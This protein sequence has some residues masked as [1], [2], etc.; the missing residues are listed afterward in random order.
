MKYHP[1]VGIWVKAR[2]KHI[3]TFIENWEKFNLIQAFCVYEVP[4][5]LPYGGLVFLHAISVNKLL[6]VARYAGYDD[7]KGWYEHTLTEDS[8]WSGECE[9]I[10]N[11]FGPDRLHTHDE[12]DF[13]HFWTEQMGVRGLFFMKDIR[14]VADVISWSDSMKV[15]QV[16]RPLGFSYKYLTIAQAREFLRLCSMNLQIE[17]KGIGSPKVTMKS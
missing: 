12:S 7:V 5:I 2:Q 8:A 4:P 17:V 3:E 10:W 1:I 16:F 6:A 13:R 9:R 14:R 15:L 11:S